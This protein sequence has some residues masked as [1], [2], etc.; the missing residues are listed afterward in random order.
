MKEVEIKL[1]GKVQ[2]VGLRN[3]VVQLATADDREIYGYV[4]NN[5][6]GS[7]EIV[8]QGQQDDLEKFIR[9]IREGTIYSE[10]TEVE[11]IWHDKSQD[12]FVAFEIW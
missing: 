5:D 7:V 3:R 2:G 6:D 1:F 11:I 10:I 4:Q 9:E 12:N 8:A